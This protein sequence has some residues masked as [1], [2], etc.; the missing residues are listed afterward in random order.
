M[1]TL[2]ENSIV[3]VAN[4][5]TNIFWYLILILS[6]V[7]PAILLLGYLD[8]LPEAL[9]F[10]I[11]IPVD[12][13]L[14]SINNPVVGVNAFSLDEATLNIL[15]SDFARL[16][17]TSYGTLAVGLLLVIVAFGYGFYQLKKLVQSSANNQVFTTKNIQRLKS[18]A[19]LVFLIDPITWLYREFVLITPEV[20]TK[21]DDNSVR[22]IFELGTDYWFIGLLLFVLAAIF[23]KGYNLYE[24]QKLTV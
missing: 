6:I 14:L 12:A 8:N 18:I 24:E 20:L 21:S 7:A 3:R 19:L 11:G 17:P 5:F 13:S 16:Y 22:I 1:D 4:F 23:E 9:D 15:L 2:K 10:P